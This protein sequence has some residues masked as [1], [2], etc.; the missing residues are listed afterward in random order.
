MGLSDGIN[1]SP[2]LRF[3]SQKMNNYSDDEELKPRNLEIMPF[4]QAEMNSDM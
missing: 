2:D 4:E 3:E 1:N